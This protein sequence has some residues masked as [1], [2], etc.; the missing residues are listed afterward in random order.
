MR[1]LYWAL[2]ILGALCLLVSL[3]VSTVMA[4]VLFLPEGWWR[5]GVGLLVLAIALRLGE[6]K[7]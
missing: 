3:A 6:E 7:K 2:I 1:N 5:G 4:P